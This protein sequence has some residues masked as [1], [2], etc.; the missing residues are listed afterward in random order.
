MGNVGTA[1]RAVVENVSFRVG[2]PT[3]QPLFLEELRTAVVVPTTQL[4]EFLVSVPTPDEPPLFEL[5][6]DSRI[7]DEILEEARVSAQAV[8]YAEGWAKGL[9]EARDHTRSERQ[10]AAAEYKKV[11][12][13]RRERTAQAVAAID[14]AAGK[15]EGRAL[16]NAEEMETAIIESAFTIAEAIIGAHLKDDEQR[17]AAALR[18]ALTL[19]PVGEHVTVTV[20][21]ADYATLTSNGAVELPECENRKVTLVQDEG[22]EPGDAVAVWESTSVDARLSKAL[23]RVRRVLW[24]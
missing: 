11:A 14:Q 8:G 17:G 1:P 24:A 12:A 19:A 2:E 15:L 20:S 18:R 5:A 6:P 21:P 3:I 7:P 22:F 4:R 13:E 16:K 23:M 9:R 10:A